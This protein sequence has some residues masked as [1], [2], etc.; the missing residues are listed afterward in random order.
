MN[1][2]LI[3]YRCTGK[4][5]VGKLLSKRLKWKFLDTDDLIE[6]KTGLSIEDIVIGKGWEEF[7]KIEKQIVKQVYKLDKYVISTGGGVILDR[8]NVNRLKKNGWVIWLKASPETIRNRMLKDQ[9]AGFIR[10]SLRG[11]DPIEE[12]RDILKKRAPFYKEAADF[13][14]KTDF[15]TQE[16]V[17]NVILDEFLRKKDAG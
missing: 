16:E 7:R 15:L 3:G 10:P 17:C 12:I 11:D 2:V 1:I 4:S 13:I 9:E 6:N 14:V 5:T 8:E